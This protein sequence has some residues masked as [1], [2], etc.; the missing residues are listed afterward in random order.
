ML[1][2]GY[3]SIL[4][5]ITHAIGAVVP[6]TTIFIFGLVLLAVVGVTLSMHVSKLT[7]R[8]TELTREMALLRDKIETG[9]GSSSD[10]TAHDKTHDKIGAH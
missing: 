1:V 6:T 9:E 7:S 2:L 8:V 4:M 10:A 5:R 3:D